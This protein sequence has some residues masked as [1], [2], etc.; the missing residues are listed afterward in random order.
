MLFMT[1]LMHAAS[2]M[3]TNSNRSFET[4]VTYLLSAMADSKGA[5]PGSRYS[6]QN[7]LN[8]R[9]R[10]QLRCHS[11]SDSITEPRSPSGK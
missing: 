6:G 11:D 9:I 1:G 5:T 7:K 10:R 4:K 8:V 3:T 2:F